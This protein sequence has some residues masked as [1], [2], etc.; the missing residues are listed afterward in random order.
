M[1]RRSVV[2][3][4]AV[5]TAVVAGAGP[6]L[7]SSSQSSKSGTIS[8]AFQ[9]IGP[10]NFTR[11]NPTSPNVSVTVDEHPIVFEGGL[12]GTSNSI[13]HT[14]GR[15]N[16]AF[17]TH[18]IE[19]FDNVTVTTDSGALVGT[20]SLTINFNATGNFTVDDQGNL[21]GGAFTGTFEIVS[22]G[23]QL[24]GLHG[25]GTVVGVPGSTS[26]FGTYTGS[27]HF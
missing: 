19:V 18:N 26:G 9:E 10:D 6:A 15:S 21:T 13:E 16:L 25:R 4:V 2:A 23:G 20:G 27:V 17:E 14:V 22:G 5:A 11:V 24:S 1:N 3:T 8:G 12:V 7:A